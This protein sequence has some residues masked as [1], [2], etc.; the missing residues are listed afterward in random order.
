MKK[1][2]LPILALAAASGAAAQSWP[3]VPREA[4]PGTRWWWLGSAVDSAN[5]S[6]NIDQY[7]ATGIGAVEITPIYGVQGNDANDIQYLSPLWMQR[8]N[9]VHSVSSPKWCDGGYESGHRLAFWRIGG[10]Y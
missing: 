1:F 8:L 3:D 7:A 6:W 9:D 2:I 4:L 10:H 5:I